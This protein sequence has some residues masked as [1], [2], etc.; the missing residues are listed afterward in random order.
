M[1]ETS[2]YKDMFIEE[3]REHLTTLNQALLDFEKDPKNKEAF[4]QIFRAAHTLKGMSATMNYEKIQKLAHKTEDTLDLIRNNKLEVDSGVVD[5]IFKCFDGM[6]KM[7]EDIAASD[8]TEFDIIGLIEQ[9]EKQMQQGD[10]IKQ[11][12][13]TKQPNPPK[14]QRKKNGKLTLNNESEKK[15]IKEIQ[16]GK[17]AYQI[18]TSVAETCSMKSI[19]AFI[20]LKKLSDRGY[21]L[22]TNPEK[23][24]I[25]D[26]KFDDTFEIIYITDQQTENVEKIMDSI[27]EL[28][29]KVVTPIL[30]E[31][32]I[33]RL[34]QSENNKNA[35]LSVSDTEI[36]QKSSDFEEKN[37]HIEPIKPV[38]IVQSIRIEMDK[39]DHFMNLIGELVISKGRLSQIS[40]DYKLDD[41][42]ETIDTIDRLTTELQDNI[43]Q[44]RMIPMKHIF[45]RFPRMI[46]D[47]ARNNG[48]NVR[49]DIHGEG[50]ELDRSI[51]DE[52]GDPLVHLLRNSI[53]HGIETPEIRKT[54]G[55]P[56]EG[57]IELIAERTRNHVHIIVRDDGKG[58]DPQ[59]M[60]DAAVKKGLKTIEEVKGLDDKE[61]I[62]LMFLP[63]LSTA[64]K[65]TSVSGRGVGM[66]VV[67]S[68]IEKLNGSVE[69]T[70]EIGQGSEFLL[71]L[72]LT[73]AIF[74][75]LFVGVADETYAIP[76]IN[77]METIHLNKED[78][79]TVHGKKTTVLREEVLPLVSLAELL[80]IQRDNK[81]DTTTMYS[82]IVQKEDKKFGLMVDKLIG[83]QEITIKNIGGSLKKT[84]GIAGVSIMGD[85]RVILVLDINTLINC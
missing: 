12:K 6:E 51:L 54:Q 63:G 59:V 34:D 53:D 57:K 9:L 56:D 82:V 68:T 48:K 5:L 42:T 62:N 11:H 61:A 47:L 44:V 77:V 24:K 43:M 39:L 8:M 52:I 10:Q 69:I 81:E 73:M 7:V 64:E 25:E 17:F 37:K 28:Q 13:S 49:L 58:I 31:N 45:D 80:D 33:L 14:L 30:Y 74:K 67:K 78:I 46:R 18:I 4:N 76:I 84:K 85:G 26:G 41:L 60:R 72:P 35:A 22:H 79:E 36:I 20:L 83:E 40:K 65:I 50:I 16:N 66:D 3:A 19:R 55:K 2:E 32:D 71:R 23:S 29:L 21:L 1:V 15:L 70:S 27:A 75:S 38:S